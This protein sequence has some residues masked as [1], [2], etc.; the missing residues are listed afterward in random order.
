MAGKNL[1]RPRASARR[2]GKNSKRESTLKGRAMNDESLLS[3]SQ[4]DPSDADRAVQLG[5]FVSLA[6]SMYGSAPSNPAPNPPP[7]LPFGYIFA[8]WVQMRDFVFESGDLTF[9]GLIAHSPDGS[10]VILAIRGTETAEEWWDDVTSL[11]PT[12]WIGPG[13]IGYGF[14]TIYQTLKVVPYGATAT[15]ATPGPVQ[16]AAPPQPFAKQVADLV[17]RIPRAGASVQ[18]RSEAPAAPPPPPINVA[19]HSLGAALATLYVVENVVLDQATVPLL[20]TFASPEVGDSDF[21]A[22]FAALPNLESWRIVNAL[23]VVPHLPIADFVHVQTPYTYNSGFETLPT[24][25]CLHS[26]ATYLHLLDPNQPIDTGCRF[27]SLAAS[28]RRES[29][30]ARAASAPAASV[31][32]PAVSTVSVSGKTITITVKIEMP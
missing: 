6:Y 15:A 25:T 11:Y 18:S 30:R 19:G 23:D 9:Y 29:A 2:S 8:A 28:A 5:Q 24:P 14:S 17:A 7:A 10:D 31:A 26:L 12:T 16:S 3:G 22:G 13:K 1:V 4:L 27:L 21:V 32:P 20:C